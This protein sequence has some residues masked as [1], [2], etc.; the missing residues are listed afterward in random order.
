MDAPALLLLLC[1]LPGS[2]KSSLAAAIR[3]A[4]A[5][6][7]AGTTPLASIAPLALTLL[8]VDDEGG[9]GSANEWSPSAWHAA[10]E[11]VSTLA[12][13]A[14][15]TAR[16][17]CSTGSRQVIIIDDTAYYRSMR[18]AYWTMA[19]AHG[20]ALLTVH[21]HAPLVLAVTRDQQRPAAACVGQ[22]VIARA[23]SAFEIPCGIGAPC[24]HSTAIAGAAIAAAATG[25]GSGFA[26]AE[27]QRALCL[28][29]SGSSPYELACAVLARLSAAET[30]QALPPP[31]DVALS[32][33]ALRAAEAESAASRAQTA[34]SEL[35]QADLILRRCVAEAVAGAG[36][37]AGRAAAAAAAA[38]AARVRALVVLR[39]RL[40]AA[41]SSGQLSAAA[42]VAAAARES[43]AFELARGGRGGRM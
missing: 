6:S 4:A 36:A 13:N 21:V 16:G 11:R 15:M 10:R 38:N 7:H 26:Q 14:L 30:W 32:P 18:R 27:A 1:G 22:A 33:A 23:A 42:A 20:A 28:D 5:S 29:A 35:H 2:G 37:G 12:E 31:V 17:R 43:F 34:A 41:D 40:A 9:G 25:G 19:R 3:S 8:S 24:R 39:E